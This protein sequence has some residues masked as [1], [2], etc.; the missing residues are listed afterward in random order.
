MAV[1][2]VTEPGVLD[3]SSWVMAEALCQ[4][5]WVVHW[6]RPLTAEALGEKETVPFNTVAFSDRT[7]VALLFPPPLVP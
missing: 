6:S 3:T 5:P 2:R 4:E 7:T 1:A